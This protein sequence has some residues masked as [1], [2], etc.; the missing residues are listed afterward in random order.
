MLSHFD[1]LLQWNRTIVLNFR[2]HKNDGVTDQ[3]SVQV[4]SGV[5]SGI[6]AELEERLDKE[7]LE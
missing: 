6:S 4:T 3:S 7:D 2:D 1:H 5:P